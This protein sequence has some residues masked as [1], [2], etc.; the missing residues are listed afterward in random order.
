MLT[1]TEWRFMQSPSFGLWS[2]L[3][4]KTIPQRIQTKE[5]NLIDVVLFL[6]K[7]KKA[8]L[9]INVVPLSQPEQIFTTA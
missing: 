2:V 6:N 5:R 4:I 7:E 8:I 3:I 9:T 1:L